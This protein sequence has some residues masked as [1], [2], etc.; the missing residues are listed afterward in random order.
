MRLS[1]LLLVCFLLNGVSLQA[2][3]NPPELTGRETPPELAANEFTTGLQDEIDGTR[4]S[5]NVSSQLAA[6][7]FEFF[8]FQPMESEA[9]QKFVDDLNV[10]DY[11][12]RKALPSARTRAALGVQVNIYN[13]KPEIKVVDGFGVI[14]NYQAA[15]ALAPVR[16][17]RDDSAEEKKEEKSDWEKAKSEMQESGGD[18]RNNFLSADGQRIT[19]SRAGFF[20]NGQTIPTYNESYV[21]ELKEGLKKA[22]SNAINVGQLGED[23]QV[24]LILKGAS[25]HEGSVWKQTV[26]SMRVSMSDFNSSKE[27]DLEKIEVNA[28]VVDKERYLRNSGGR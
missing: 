26:L 7:N 4:L 6:P 1:C 10:L 18:L 25:W 3:D 2:Q 19:S 5:Y 13:S 27:I 24:L 17:K 14:M 9:K 20:A 16:E 22:L 21:D 8:S 23:D 28:E 15:I 12:V 11:M